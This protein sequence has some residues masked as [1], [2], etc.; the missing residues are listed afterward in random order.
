MPPAGILRR[1]TFVAG[2]LP[3]DRGWIPR[4]RAHTHS[5]TNVHTLTQ[6]GLWSPQSQTKEGDC[7][8]A[9]SPEYLP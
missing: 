1:S 6:A 4:V 8:P 3:G 2:Q 7:Y 5:H 9:H